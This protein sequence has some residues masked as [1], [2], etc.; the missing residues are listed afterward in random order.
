MMEKRFRLGRHGEQLWTREK[1]RQ[2]RG[3]IAGILEELETGDVLVIDGTGVEVFDFSFA[4]ELFSRTL[5][6]LVPEYPGRFVIVDNLTEYASENLSKA[7]ES[8]NQI[9]IER[10]KEKLLLL[11]KVHPVD[12]ETFAEIARA[13]EAVSAGTLSRKLEVNLT[14]MNERLSKLAGLGIVRREKSSSA[15]G[16][17]QYVYRLLS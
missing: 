12:Q 17:E 13:G 4:N 5:S 16:R 3:Q 15:S 14:A 7:L 8:T 6:T 11:G 9:M 1:A 2:I 10:R